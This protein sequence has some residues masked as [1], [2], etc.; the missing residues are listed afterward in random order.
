[1]KLYQVMETILKRQNVAIPNYIKDGLSPSIT[2]RDYQETAL[3][4]FL[5]YEAD[6][7]SRRYPAHLLFHM[8][9]GSGK[10]VIM[11]ALILHLYQ[12]GYRNFLF[13]V[14]SSNII[15]KT[16]ENFLSL[17]SSKYLFANPVVLNG[18][19]INIQKVFNFDDAVNEDINIHFTT[20][21]GLHF[22]LN[23]PKESA[24]TYED[25]KNKNLVLISDE[26][27]HIN[28]LTRARKLNQT[29]LKHE[30][31]WERT[32]QKILKGNKNN[33]LLE[34]TATID[35]ENDNIKEKYEDKIIY[36]YSL[37]QFRLE[38]YSKEV[39]LR[40][41][42]ID[43]LE[44][45]FQAVLFSQYRRK[46]AKE[47]RLPVKPVIL[48]K[49]KTIRESKNNTEDFI[50]FIS[51]L[52]GQ[53]IQK[54]EE[55]YCQDPSLGKIYRYFFKDKR[56]S[57]E[58]FAM[59]LKGEFSDDRIINVNNA[60]DLKSYQIQVNSLED[61]D[62]EIR[63]VFAVDKLNEGW[64]VLNLFDIARLYETRDSRKNQVGET[65]LQ[66]AQLIGRGARYYPFID[67][68]RP[69]ESKEKRKYDQDTSHPL[70][71]LEE[72]HYHCSHNPKYI[73]EIKNALQKTGMMDEPQ[74]K[75][76][77]VK[78]CFK[79]TAFYKEGFIYVN[80]KIKNKNENKH[81]LKDYDISRQYDYPTI[82]TAS[83]I[84]E[85]DL[86]NKRT[87]S[88]TEELVSEKVLL[89]DIVILRRV[90]DEID[91]FTFDNIKTYLPYLDSMDD[92]FQDVAKR[93]S[94][95]VR[96]DREKIN[97]LS[98]SQKKDIYYFVLTEI[99]RHVKKQ[100]S[101]FIGTKEFRRRRVQEVIK[102][103]HVYINDANKLAVLVSDGIFENSWYV[104]EE[105]FINGYEKN[106]VQ[107][108]KDKAR[109]I[110]EKYDEFYLVRNEK[111][112]KLYSF[113][114]GHGLEPDFLLFAIKKDNATENLIY[115]LFMEPKGEDR[116]QHNAW[117]EKF[118]KE[119][120]QDDRA[121]NLY[122]GAEYRIVGLPFYTESKKYDFHKAFEEEL[123][124][125]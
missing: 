80:E 27:H 5:C 34:F 105:N 89:D 11:A 17:N 94:A 6:E 106:L 101:E 125:K 71:A 100:S 57:Y 40:Q 23:N 76:I 90:A 96:G 47:Y 54:S 39:I 22:N 48:M 121:R 32:V 93:F 30:D 50:K 56:L 115:Q 9:T 37:K 53:D 118:L 51:K 16:K 68:K 97:N 55:K 62:N 79:Q 86:G 44:R 113:D 65:T 74:R 29:E 69:D 99:K 102:D 8:A 91:F 19:K 123:G 64:D 114:G 85:S 88:G 95:Y 108:V 82:L 60:D 67:T 31:S 28:R 24:V 70:R 107:Y 41:S 25:F 14:N 104:Y 75:L 18:K 46:V 117:K 58:N 120:R 87:V 38:G 1:M 124:I 111:L 45:M 98:R 84:E 72:L 13:F 119:I 81:F 12:Q 59:E 10:T 7:L 109:K 2:L 20:I 92:L 63:V 42:H 116:E 83:T 122:E 26:A 4:H 43:P 15:E 21:Q 33:F 77:R 35:M 78:E 112:V 3:R 52:T 103:K 61:E 73:S 49:S 36:D 110:R 66:E